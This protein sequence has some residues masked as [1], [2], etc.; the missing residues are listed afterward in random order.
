MDADLIIGSLY[1]SSGRVY[2]TDSKVDQ[3][4]KQQRGELDND[5]RRALIGEILKLSGEFLPYAPLYNEIHAYGVQDR[6]KWTPRP[7]ERLYFQT[8]EIVQK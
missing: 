3:L 6:I 5:K 8:A 7:D 4:A 2:W 1:D